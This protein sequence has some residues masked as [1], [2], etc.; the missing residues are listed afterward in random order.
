VIEPVRVDRPDGSYSLI[1]YMDEATFTVVPKA[2]ADFVM[3]SEYDAD[4]V[5]VMETAGRVSRELRRN[6]NIT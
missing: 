2:E 3:I 6:A 1:V 4:G 5:M